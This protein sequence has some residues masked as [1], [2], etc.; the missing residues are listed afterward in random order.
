ML[1]RVRI[2]VLAAAVV[3]GM[4][5]CS[6]SSSPGSSTCTLAAP[7]QTDWRLTTSGTTLRDSLGRVVLL[8][9]VDAGG[10][11]KFAPYMP[12][13]YASDSAFTAALNSYMDRA[14]TWGIDSMRV[15]WTWAA[16]EPTKGT[17]DMGWLAK[18]KE[19]L[20]AAWARGIYTVVDFH[21]DIYSECL[22]GDGFPCWTLP[23]PGPPH[24]DCPLW[25]ADYSTGPVEAAFDAFWAV[26]GPVQT[27]Y[28]A[29]WDTM[30]AAVAEVPGVIGLEPIN[31]PSTGAQNAQTFEATTLTDFF[32]RMI[33]HFTGK[34]P[35]T[36]VFVDDTG[37][38]G[39]L[40]LTTMNRPTG[41]FVFAP[42]FYPVINPRPEN[43]QP[44]MQYWADFA[45]KWNVPVWIGEFG[46]SDTKP[47]APSYMTAHYDAFDALGLGAAEWEYSV[48]TTTWNGETDSIVAADGTEYPVAK[49]VIRPYARAVA[50]SGVTQKYA[51]D[52]GAFT[53][54]WTAAP[55]ITEVSVPARAYPDGTTVSVS[56]GCY[57]ATSVPG[58]VLVDASKASGTVTLSITSPV[59]LSDGG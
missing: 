26:G 6:S 28:L 44:K 59:A 22:C 16:L 56:A 23:S 48:E 54:T 51:A 9:G 33:A 24:H 25:S 46:M 12:F 35:K 50:G 37:V 55:G 5:A 8:R 20:A 31:E 47:N 2:W 53:L 19:L 29:A 49:A 52:T 38:A 41:N 14:A 30:I 18:Y 32:S 36:L 42:H 27:E 13:E 7:T 10:R 3:V 58:K 34:A 15:P 11:S 1:A 57:D 43:V 17:Y 40:V 4:S 45:T 39:T 21:Q